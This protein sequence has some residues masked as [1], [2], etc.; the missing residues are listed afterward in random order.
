MALTF[1]N[2]KDLMADEI[3][4]SDNATNN[5]LYLNMAAREVWRYGAWQER[6]KRDFVNTVA[7]IT[8]GTVD[9]V[10]GDATVTEAA[11]TDDW[12]SPS[13][14]GRKFALGYNK[15]FYNIATVTD[16][17][18]FELSNAYAGETVSGTTFVIYDDVV[19]LASDVG[20]LTHVWLH[21]ADRGYPLQVLTEKNVEHFGRYPRSTDRPWYAALIEHD[22]SGNRQLRIGPFAPDAVYRIEYRYLKEFTE[23]SGDSDTHGL[24]PDLDHVILTLALA[25]A[26]RRDHFTRSS[27]MRALAMQ[28][29]R[30]AWMRFRPSTDPSYLVP[31]S[32]L[33]PFMDLPV[34]LDSLEI[35]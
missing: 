21:D 16:A 31:R 8:A 19:S 22:S 33:R 10:N 13:V 15:T 3:G 35:P 14:A 9:L 23:M 6:L 32:E 17:D 18:N 26:Y 11:G 27:R 1:L 30:Q 12:T 25:Y 34:N 29:L 28:E 5:G 20:T 24:N 2:M 7:P 4:D